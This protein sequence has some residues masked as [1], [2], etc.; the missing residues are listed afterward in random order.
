MV[1]DFAPLTT[2]RCRLGEGPAWVP[3]LGQL[4]WLDIHRDTVHRYDWQSGESEADTLSDRSTFVVPCA[5]GSA[6]GGRQKGLFRVPEQGPRALLTVPVSERVPVSLVVPVE[7]ETPDTSL[8]DGKTGPDGRLYFGTRDLA[9]RRAMGGL[10]RLDDDLVARRLAG[11]V[12]A[13]NGLDWSPDASVLY[14]VDSGDYLVWAFDFDARDGS[15]SRKRVFASVAEPDGLPDGLTVDAAG[16]VWV[17]LYGGG[18]LHR[19]A[20][21]G[22]LTEVVPVPVRYPTSCAFAGPGLDMLVVTSAYARIEDA[23]D[24]P[25][26]LDGAVLAAETGAVGKPIALCRTPL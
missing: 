11:R 1:T 19:Y 6:I 7:T 23:G 24:T 26:E 18:R 10:Y 2:A 21:D 15:V 12:T 8:N 9:Q 20:P 5:D 16:G 14:F 22:R 13:G 17:A 4:W 25:S 3:S